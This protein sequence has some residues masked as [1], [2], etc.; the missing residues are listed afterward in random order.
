MRKW[1]IGTIALAALSAPATAQEGAD[2]LVQELY[3]LESIPTNSGDIDRFFARDLARAIKRDIRGGEVGETNGG[4]YRYNAQDFKIT[5]L[6]FERT[7]NR[8][9]GVVTVSFKNFDK[10]ET[11]TYAM[12]LARRGWRI[13]DVRPTGWAMRDALKLP[14]VPVDC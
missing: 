12:C 10:P 11:V 14:S 7:T 2:R 9:G 13:T 4:D 3:K 8:L 5:D 6:K 1:I